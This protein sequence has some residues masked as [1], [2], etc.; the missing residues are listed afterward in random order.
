[1]SARDEGARRMAQRESLLLSL[2]RMM[3][4]RKDAERGGMEQEARES[5]GR[6][7]ERTRLSLLPR[8]APLLLVVLLS[9]VGF[10]DLSRDAVRGFRSV[11]SP[12]FRDWPPDEVV[13][14]GNLRMLLAEMVALRFLFARMGCRDLAVTACM[15]TATNILAGVVFLDK[16]GRAPNWE[17]WQE[18]FS[19]VAP[20]KSL[21]QWKA[22]VE[23][24][25]DEIQVFSHQSSLV[26]RVRVACQFIEKFTPDAC[27]LLTRALDEIRATIMSN[28]SAYDLEELAS[29]R[30]CERKLS[31]IVPS[32]FFEQL[33]RCATAN[34][35]AAANAAAARAEAGRK[36]AETAARV[37]AERQAAT[38][39]EAERKAAEAAA[40]A[41][42]ERK[43]AEAAV[44]A[45][46][47]RKA[48]E[49]AARAEAERKAA[50]AAARAEAERTAA[51]A[52][53]RAETERK[54]AEAAARAET[55]R[56]AAE[57]AARAEAER[58]TAEAAV[59]AE[60]ERKA[61]AARAETERKAA[62]RAEAER[63]AAEA[64]ARAETE[65]K[66]AERKAAEAT[67]RA[68]EEAVAHAQAVAAKILNPGENVVADRT[69]SSAADLGVPVT[70]DSL[71]LDALKASRTDLYTLA[72]TIANNATHYAALSKKVDDFGEN[73]GA[74]GA[75]GEWVLDSELESNYAQ[76]VCTLALVRRISTKPPKISDFMLVREGPVQRLA[77][78]LQKHADRRRENLLS[79]VT[80]LNTEKSSV[81]HEEWTSVEDALPT[82][83]PMWDREKV[84]RLILQLCLCTEYTVEGNFFVTLDEVKDA[85]RKTLPSRETD[86]SRAPFDIAEELVL[87]KKFTLAE[88]KKRV[89]MEETD[90]RQRYYLAPTVPFYSTTVREVL[91]PIVYSKEKELLETFPDDISLVH[92]YPLT[93]APR[94]RRISNTVAFV[95]ADFSVNGRDI[96]QDLTFSEQGFIDKW[97]KLRREYDALVEHRDTLYKAMSDL[98]FKAPKMPFWGNVPL[99][100]DVITRPFQQ[101]IDEKIE[102]AETVR[103]C[104]DETYGPHKVYVE[105]CKKVA[106]D[107]ATNRGII[108]GFRIKF[109]A[110]DE[111]I[112]APEGL[113][114]GVVGDYHRLVNYLR[115][116]R[117]PIK[118]GEERKSEQANGRFFRDL[119]FPSIEETAIDFGA[120]EGDHVFVLSLIP[121]SAST[122]ALLGGGDLPSDVQFSEEASRAALSV[123]RDTNSSLDV[124]M[125]KIAQIAGGG[126]ATPTTVRDFW[127]FVESNAE[128]RKDL[129]TPSLVP[130]KELL[131]LRSWIRV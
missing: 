35:T 39:A 12:F 83:S 37:E 112:P 71:I 80:S 113:E 94:Q 1:M 7:L 9:C 79:W 116:A 103:A 101:F 100:L 62:A 13:V 78:G 14:R 17:A 48:A 53:A 52:A 38:R 26:T 46:A 15:D 54:A 75:A 61:A 97:T 47:E 73:F 30:L 24:I 25:P 56:K 122:A 44:R 66:E 114:R 84:D 127:E 20:E 11:Q 119:F 92:L 49:A 110:Q 102:A 34:A 93:A 72:T 8:D 96:Q 45:D 125:C 69:A 18:F 59:R 55:E 124:H 89:D 107:N 115:D 106:D 85:T 51:E 31:T 57:A 131:L 27:F 36:V 19:L 68:E 42:A 87:D 109:L 5:A 64:A 90:I 123:T 22:T 58:K 40:R 28:P 81:N 129:D 4:D 98:D 63:K 117:A 16:L 74:A 130:I 86:D 10:E 6:I 65:R 43:A 3:R 121:L 82:L 70:V 88:L 76:A 60:A 128:L 105:I 111:K 99:D 126:L 21:D 67:A 91:V 95:G 41:E 33:A 108:N 77:K 2:T 120:K 118:R 104:F 50:E 32:T 23:H 29:L